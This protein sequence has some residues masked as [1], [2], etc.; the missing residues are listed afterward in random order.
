MTCHSRGGSTKPISCSF[1]KRNG[2]LVLLIGDLH[3]VHWFPA[4][5]AVARDRGWRLVTMTKSACTFV[6]VVPLHGG[7]PADEC[8]IW[9]RKAFAKVKRLHPALVI[10][11]ALDNYHF[12][13]DGGWPMSSR[14]EAH[15]AQG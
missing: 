5:L 6:D 7:Q 12:V 8:V 3:A 14:S 1:G 15:G 4:I 10:A 13:G 11:S 9:R 2:K